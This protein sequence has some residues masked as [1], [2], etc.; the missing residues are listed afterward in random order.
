MKGDERER[1]RDRET[2]REREFVCVYVYVKARE[3]KLW[4]MNFKEKKEITS[5]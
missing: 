3:N 5:T 4:D 2:E 1:V